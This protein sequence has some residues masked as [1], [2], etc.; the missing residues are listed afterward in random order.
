VSERS[1]AFLRDHYPDASVADWN[2]WRWQN[3]HRVRTLADLERMIDLSDDES[4]AIRRH[5]GGFD[6][7]LA[8]YR[9]AGTWRV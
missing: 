4:A 3:R 6:A 8:S 1:A 7:V 9:C 5:T 2:D